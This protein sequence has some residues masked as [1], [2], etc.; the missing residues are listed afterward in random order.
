[1]GLFFWSCAL[2]FWLLSTK[3][4]EVKGEGV[5]WFFFF[6]PSRSIWGRAVHEVCFCFALLWVVWVVSVVWVVFS[7]VGWVV[8]LLF[9]FSFFFFS[10]LQRLLY[11][12]VTLHLVWEGEGE[13]GD[14]DDDDEVQQAG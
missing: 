9:F 4:C 2:F 11:C 8:H 12:R 6:P 7:R 1:M 13:G 14:D 10:F 3:S 5:V